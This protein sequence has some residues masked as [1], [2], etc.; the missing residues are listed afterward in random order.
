MR[1]DFRHRA[2]RCLQGY[3]LCAALLLNRGGEYDEYPQ[4]KRNLDTDMKGRGL[5]EVSQKYEEASHAR[6]QTCR[7]GGSK[8]DQP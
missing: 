3:E 8:E 6:G 2:S 1:P 4:R 7:T 5:G